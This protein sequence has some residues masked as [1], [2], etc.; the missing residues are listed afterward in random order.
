MRLKQLQSTHDVNRLP[1]YL[2]SFLGAENRNAQ[3][4]LRGCQELRNKLSTPFGL[5]VKVIGA[6]K[7]RCA[8]L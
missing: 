4:G 3:A 7:G 1:V 6:Q 2:H 8:D 5:Y